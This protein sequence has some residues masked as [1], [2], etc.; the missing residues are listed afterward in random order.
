MKFSDQFM[1][2][3]DSEV[4]CGMVKRI[5]R[6]SLSIYNYTQLAQFKKR[7][8]EVTEACRGL[9]IHDDG[10]IIARPFTKFYNWEE[11]SEE[12]RVSFSIGKV[13]EI[14]TK[15]DGSLIIAFYFQDQWYTITRG[16]WDSPQAIA[17]KE[18]LTEEFLNGGKKGKTYLFELTGPSN[19]NVT[20]G[21]D[22]DELILLGII[23]TKTGEDASAEDIRRFAGYFKFSIPKC[24]TAEEF[25]FSKIKGSNDPNFEGVVIKNE[26]GARC[27]IKSDLYV[28]LHR[29]VTGMNPKRVYS[30]WSSIK[31]GEAPLTWEGIPDEFFKEIKESLSDLDQAWKE[32]RQ[33][34]Y[35]DWEKCISLKEEGLSR[36]D[37]AVNYKHLI[38]VL[39]AAWSK[40]DPEKVAE[41]LFSKI[42]G[43]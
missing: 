41:K 2:K 16:A 11:L 19:R 30:L 32:H 1:K 33:T 17:A 38:P 13:K 39:D 7:M 4:Q 3:L 42:H 20:R 22:R 28:R 10:T 31:G 35:S 18:L 43:G 8:N 25:D 36:K 37:I 9:V 24:W 29:L 12:K 40:T 15:E 6:G 5:G 14:W 34:V 21:Y 27:K 23:D 26:D